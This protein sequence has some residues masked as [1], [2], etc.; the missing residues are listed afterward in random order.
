MIIIKENLLYEGLHYE[1][2]KACQGLEIF[3]PWLYTA[4]PSKDV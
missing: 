1:V 2:I 3:N 4:Q